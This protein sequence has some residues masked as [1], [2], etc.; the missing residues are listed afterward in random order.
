[1]SQWKEQ[2]IRWIGKWFLNRCLFTAW[3]KGIYV[4]AFLD[5]EDISNTCRWALIHPAPGVQGWA[6]LGRVAVDE[7]GRH[8]VNPE[9]GD[10]DTYWGIYRCVSWQ[11]KPGYIVTPEWGIESLS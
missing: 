11:S 3:G 1:M 8:K 10:F 4:N 7:N 6:V 9:T 5:G 2:V